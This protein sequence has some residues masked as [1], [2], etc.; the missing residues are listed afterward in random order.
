MS[1]GLMGLHF[2]DVVN[3]LTGKDPYMVLADFADFAKARQY[4]NNL[5]KDTIKWNSM[6]LCNIANA[7]IFSSDRSIKEYAN[8]IWHAKPLNE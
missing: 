8:N 6:S 4:V 3:S 1:S 7:G 5:Y 2:D